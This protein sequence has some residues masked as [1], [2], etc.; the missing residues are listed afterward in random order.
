MFKLFAAA[1]ALAVC[2]VTAPSAF[3]QP[4][5]RPD[6]P[7]TITVLGNGEAQRAADY[8][9]ITGSVEAEAPD[10]L[11]A[12]KAMAARRDAA[13]AKLLRLA[14]V[15]Q[16]S[17]ETQDI[18]FKPV[19]PPGCGSG[20][21]DEEAPP[22][23]GKCAA[24]AVRASVKLAVTVRPADQVGAAAS[25]AVQLGLKEVQL[26]ESGVDDP[27]GLTAEALR[28]AYD[29]AERQAE[30]LA[31]VSQ[32]KL[33]RLI[34]L[35]RGSRYPEVDS[36]GLLNNA[37]ALPIHQPPPPPPPISPDVAL[38]LTPPKVKQSAVVTAVFELER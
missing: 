29:D 10:Q 14:D 28:A 24:I 33:G 12:L 23:N 19:L 31:I 22:S 7:G 16:V 26:G 3:S 34:Q 1:G 30:L 15:K 37:P 2:A 20:A 21:L 35:S 5:G 32:R 9:S 8:V 27:K 36:E 25:L 18:A 38:K 13:E 6:A 4:A 17:V 11:S